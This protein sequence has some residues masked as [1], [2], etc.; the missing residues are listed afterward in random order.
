MLWISREKRFWNVMSPPSW[1]GKL[2][3][4]DVV[5]L[6][7]FIWCTK[8][9][10]HP[11]QQPWPKKTV[12][13]SGLFQVKIKIENGNWQIFRIHGRIYWLRLVFNAEFC[14]ILSCEFLVDI[15][16][17]KSRIQ[18]MYLNTKI[19]I[20]HEYETVLMGRADILKYLAGFYFEF[21]ASM[22]DKQKG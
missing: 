17:Q 1:A 14:S 16:R 9:L 22:P 11:L 5:W 20:R 13:Y 18:L 4:H 2:Q 7:C 6:D 10:R 8:S 15:I 19:W 12:S 3:A 21:R